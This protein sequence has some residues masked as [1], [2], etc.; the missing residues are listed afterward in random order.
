MAT[1]EKAIS[2]MIGQEAKDAAEAAQATADAAMPKSGGTFT[3]DAV[4]ASKMDNGAAIRN[5]VV[6][7]A[8]TDLSTLSVPVGT[9]VMEKK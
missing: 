3:G 9:I 5:I 6:V 4:A 1:I 2:L 8:G 7:E